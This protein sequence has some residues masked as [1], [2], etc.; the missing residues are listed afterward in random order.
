MSP[1][2]G[3]L[4]TI[5]SPVGPDNFNPNV[6]DPLDVGEPLDWLIDEDWSVFSETLSGTERRMDLLEAILNARC[7]N[8][9]WRSDKKGVLEVFD[10]LELYTSRQGVADYK[11]ID[12]WDEH[13]QEVI[14]RRGRA[15][16]FG[17]GKAT[18]NRIANA[19]ALGAS[20]YRA[21]PG[22]NTV[23]RGGFSIAE[24]PY[25]DGEIGAP[26]NASA[27]RANRKD[28]VV[29]YCADQ[30]ATA[31]A[32]VRPAQG[33]FV[34]LGRFKAKRDLKLLDLVMSRPAINPFTD[35]DLRMAVETQALFAAFARDLETP[36]RRSDDDTTYLPSQ[37]LTDAVRRAG[38][39]GIRYPSAM[40]PGGSNIV[41]FDP[42]DAEFVDSQ[43]VEITSVNVKFE[44]WARAR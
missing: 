7:T 43:L 18:L 19:L 5:Y 1:Y 9:E 13:K 44:P 3:N 38:F 21:R 39:D 4:M 12:A 26:P 10:S 6:E 31:V 41:L 29:F 2:F 37:N 40:N 33:F 32:E 42:A 34:S 14:I 27:G 30:D 20:L 35:N 11:L 17:V 23:R 22:F 25:R 24:Q 28:Q 36:L 16:P 15:R 8:S